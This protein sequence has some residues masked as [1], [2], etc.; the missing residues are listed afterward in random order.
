MTLGATLR[1]VAQEGSRL[2]WDAWYPVAHAAANGSQQLVEAVGTLNSDEQYTLLDNLSAD[3]GPLAD[4]V[5]ATLA[6]HAEAFEDE[7]IRSYLLQDSA[8]ALARRR[9]FLT[10]LADQLRATIGRLTE[11]Q[12]SGFDAASEIA[13]LEEQRNTLRAKQ[14]ES[15]HQEITE[16]EWEIARLETLQSRLAS[17]DAD[18]RR[19][20]RDALQ[21]E[22][23][24]LRAERESIEV[25]VGDAVSQRDEAN[26]ALV[27]V[28]ERHSALVEE[29]AEIQAQ[30]AATEAQVEQMNAELPAARARRAALAAQRVEL[31][32]EQ[33]RLEHLIDSPLG[34]E[35]ARLLEDVKAMYRNLPEDEAD[36]MFG[37][38]RSTRRS[39]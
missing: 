9:A 25:S 14:I 32:E 8:A 5:L 2:E 24:L 18:A 11:H 7:Q 34:D 27:D 6:A 3:G 10:Q 29:A 15:G 22:T 16:L 36:T 30:I 19:T 39:N 35:A 20:T 17:Y 38:A 23:S 21:N 4:F 12:Q 37:A 13:A 31:G 26:S 28:R 1:T 33:S